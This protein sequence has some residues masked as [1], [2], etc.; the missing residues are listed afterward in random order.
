[1][2]AITSNGIRPLIKVWKREIWDICLL[3]FSAIM[4]AR[5]SDRECVTVFN[6]TD[7]AD[8]IP[9]SL[10]YTLIKCASSWKWT[11]NGKCCVLTCG[12]SHNLWNKIY[13]CVVCNISWSL[14]PYLN[15]Y[16]FF[17]SEFLISYIAPIAVILCSSTCIFYG[18]LFPMWRTVKLRHEHNLW[19]VTHWFLKRWRYIMAGFI[20]EML[21]QPTCNR[22]R[23]KA[24]W[25]IN[26]SCC[27]ASVFYSPPGIIAVSHHGL[28]HEEN[29]LNS[30]I[31]CSSVNV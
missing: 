7:L 18:G 16:R 23:P 27:F 13:I 21:T 30:V 11:W 22:N 12:L 9:A 3:H 25:L 28:S 29:T 19:D 17:I 14:F 8:I 26:L 31:F 1:M 15:I 5:S 24:S 20:L 10:V 2:K 4:A 6:G